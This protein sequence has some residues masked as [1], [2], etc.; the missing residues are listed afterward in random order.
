MSDLAKVIDLVEAEVGK[1]REPIVTRVS[2]RRD[3]YQVLVSCIL[4]LRTKD[5]TTAKASG[6]LF[7]RAK[8]PEGMVKL[9]EEE[10]GSM[11][12]PVNYY[13]TKAKNIK[14]IS[15]ILIE[16]Y[17]SRVPEDF[18]KLMEL[19]GV[20]RKT[21]NIVT[22]FGFGKMGMPVDVHCHRIPNRLGWVKTKTP[23]QT[24]FALR[25]LIPRTHWMKFNDV[26]VTFGQNICKPVRPLCE[27]CPVTKYC[28]YY[29][30][31]TR[32]TAVPAERKGGT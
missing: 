25:K 21:A 7:H 8:T 12:N 32:S 4:S 10:I 22:V 15:R 26:F 17:G 9:S 13:K 29:V 3:P 2:R 19:P 14:R 5:E 31:R 28:E 23:E 20:G 30:E 24:E 16:R 27:K 18:D 6:K 11:I 1:Y